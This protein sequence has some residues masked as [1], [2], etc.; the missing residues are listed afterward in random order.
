MT[1]GWDRSGTDAFASWQ[2]WGELA[3][4]DLMHWMRDGLHRLAESTACVDAEERRRR[5]RGGVCAYEGADA[6]ADCNDGSIG[7]AAVASV[8][9]TEAAAFA[10]C[11]A[12]EGVQPAQCSSSADTRVGAPPRP[13]APDASPMPH[14]PAAAAATLAGFSAASEEPPPPPPPLPVAQVRGAAP[15]VAQAAAELPSSTVAHEI[16]PQAT[17]QAPRSHSCSALPPPPPPPPPRAASAAGVVAVAAPPPPPP[18]QQR[19]SSATPQTQLP[20][21]G[22]ATAADS[23]DDCDDFVPSRC[24][25]PAGH[26]LERFSTP[27]DD[28]RCDICAR[29][30]PRGT[31]MRGCRWCNH[32]VC[33]RCSCAV[34]ATGSAGA[35]AAAAVAA[36]GARAVTA[37]TAVSAGAGAARFRPATY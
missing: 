22:F 25:C 19:Q 30:L 27:V 36:A 3:G 1:H 18:R 23:D 2:V 9:A 24:R 26:P 28:Y 16:S 14:S 32:D 12:A 21:L 10:S 8:A 31:S 13:H 17:A 7:G 15:Q 4:K 6:D 37:V 20:A 11:G 29:A 35:R 34:A 5:Y 33:D